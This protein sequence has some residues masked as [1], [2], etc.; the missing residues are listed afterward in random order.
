MVSWRGGVL[1]S[2]VSEPPAQ[3]VAT[4]GVRGVTFFVRLDR[5][6]L[7][8]VA[9]LIDLGRLTPTVESVFP[10]DRKRGL[11]AHV[12]GKIVLRVMDP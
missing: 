5:A 11:T 6:E 3:R 8:E 4:R 1:V 10:L 2:T 12:R 7:V 9:R